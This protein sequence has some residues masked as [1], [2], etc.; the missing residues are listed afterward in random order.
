MEVRI[1]SETKLWY[2]ADY[3]RNIKQLCGEQMSVNMMIQR[4]KLKDR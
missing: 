2:V 3:V 4:T 1:K